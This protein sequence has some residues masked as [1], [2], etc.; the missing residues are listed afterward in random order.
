MEGVTGGVEE[1]SRGVTRV[2]REEGCHLR[3]ESDRE[4][5]VSLEEWE[6]SPEK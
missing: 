2:V 1:G 3:V 5:E 4:V 6:V